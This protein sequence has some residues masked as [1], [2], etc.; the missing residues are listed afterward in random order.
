MFQKFTLDIQKAIK[1][2]MKISAFYYWKAM[3]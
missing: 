1:D 2:S 3:V